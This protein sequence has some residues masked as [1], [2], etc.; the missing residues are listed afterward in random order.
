MS[1]DP[2]SMNRQERVAFWRTHVEAQRSSGLNVAAY[3]R[4]EHISSK[5][6]EYSIGLGLLDST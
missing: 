1:E 6:Q 2:K 4:R 3:C 5:N